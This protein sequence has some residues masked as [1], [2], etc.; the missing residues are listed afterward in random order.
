M[1][2][3]EATEDSLNGTESQMSGFSGAQTSDART[4]SAGEAITNM[5]QRGGVCGATRK[6][7]YIIPEHA[8]PHSQG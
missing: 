3:K 8:R 1:C 6:V 2:A 7:G 4:G 5:S